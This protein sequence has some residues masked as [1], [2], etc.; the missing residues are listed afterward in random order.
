MAMS[1][2]GEFKNGKPNGDG[3]FTWLDG[4][5][6]DGQWKD[7]V[8]DGKGTLTF[9]KIL[10]ISRQMEMHMRATGTMENRTAK[11]H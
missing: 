5:K 8:R 11:E 1:T 2:K 10:T 4:R 3:I 7:G 9:A 6:Y